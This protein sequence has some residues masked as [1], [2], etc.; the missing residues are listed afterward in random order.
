MEYHFLLIRN[1]YSLNSTFN[2]LFFD[3]TSLCNYVSSFITMPLN[4]IGESKCVVLVLNVS[5]VFMYKC[6]SQKLMLGSENCQ[7]L[8]FGSVIKIA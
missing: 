8:R 7:T 1:I 2:Y 5:H 6:M 3:E 4:N